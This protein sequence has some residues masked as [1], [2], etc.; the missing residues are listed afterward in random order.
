[1]KHYNIFQDEDGN[2]SMARF[3]IFCALIMGIYTGATIPWIDAIKQ[4]GALQ[5]AL[6]FFTIAVSGK[7]LTKFSERK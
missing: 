5:A 3:A 4:P 6:G 1:M 7:A 2:Y